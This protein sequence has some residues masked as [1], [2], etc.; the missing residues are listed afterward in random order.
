[1]V[2]SLL[3][4]FFFFFFFVALSLLQSVNK[5]LLVDRDSADQ[6]LAESQRHF[7]KEEEYIPLHPMQGAVSPELLLLL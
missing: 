1:M 2:T 4:L 7:G 5:L 6:S 3:F